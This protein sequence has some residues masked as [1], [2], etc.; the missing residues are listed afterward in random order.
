MVTAPPALTRDVDEIMPGAIADRR[1]LHQYPELGFQEFETSRFVAER[2]EALGLNEIRTGI[3]KTGVIGLLK[4]GKPGKVVALR[5]DMDALPIDEENDVEYRSKRPGVMHAC[6]HD[7]HVSMLLGVARVRAARRAEIP[8]TVMFIFQPGEEGL[9]GAKAM[10]ADGALENPAPDAIFGLHIWQDTPS[11]VVEVHD[12]IA[13]VAGDGF[14]MTIKGK[15]GHGATPQYTIDPIAI[16][17]AI[18]G[19]LQTVMSRNTDPVLPGVVTIGAFHAG[20]AANVIPSTAELRGTIRTVTPEQ[21][22][23]AHERVK[24]VAEG[25]AAAMGAEIEA[26]ILFGVPAT[27]NSPAMAA[28]VRDVAI[29]IAGADRVVEGSLKA[30]SEDMSEFLN[31]V[32]GCYFFVGSRNEEKGYVWGHHHARFDIDEEAMAVGI[33]TLAGS[34]LRFLEQNA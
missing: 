15:G 14:R 16:G 17:A 5:A 3:G 7:A 6:G 31:R 4:G 1:H 25:I 20:D 23:F 18:V 11:G 30:A 26:N 34:A 8:G 32:P 24:G 21:R 27:V 33:G 19:G 13:M 10:I 9:G 2:L 22:A 12:T 29:E 28:I